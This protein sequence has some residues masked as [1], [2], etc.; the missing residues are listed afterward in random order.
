M[1]YQR[2]RGSP[3]QSSFNCFFYLI[4]TLSKYF[5]IDRAVARASARAQISVE[6]RTPLLTRG[7]LPRNTCFSIELETAAAT[8]TSLNSG[9]EQFFEVENVYVC[10]IVLQDCENKC[11]CGFFRSEL[12]EI[13]SRKLD[14]FAYRV[15]RDR[16]L[17]IATQR[18]E[19]P[20][21]G[22]HSIAR[23]CFATS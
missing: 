6:R 3:T 17:L 19:M 8:L 12:G 15:Y 7:L 1:S 16:E 2:K 20:G 23:S 18:N 22:A 5:H 11:A 10:A 4:L 14:R 13:A 21:H 9:W